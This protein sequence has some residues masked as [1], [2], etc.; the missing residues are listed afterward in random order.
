MFD[1]KPFKS[2]QVKDVNGPANEVF[3]V[4]KNLVINDSSF[5]TFNQQLSEQLLV[6]HRVHSM[7]E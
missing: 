6:T 1:G 4:F 2:M 3:F 5:Y 7:C